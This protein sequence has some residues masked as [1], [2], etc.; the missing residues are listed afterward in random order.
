MP[1]NSSRNPKVVPKA[2]QQEKK[3]VGAH[4]L[5]QN[6]LGVRGRVEALNDSR[7][8]SQMKVQ[9]EVNL[10]NQKMRAINAS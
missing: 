5:T 10:H 9:D 3:K 2:K 7:T 4:S 6:T 8:N 1:P